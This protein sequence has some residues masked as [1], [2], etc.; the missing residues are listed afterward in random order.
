MLIRSGLALIVLG[1]VTGLAGL[2]AFVGRIAALP[3]NL[4]GAA[5]AAAVFSTLQAF[6]G[7]ESTWHACSGHSFNASSAG[8]TALTMT[9]AGRRTVG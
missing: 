5:A 1:A 4:Y 6:S 2:S 3:V 7:V 8:T 9:T